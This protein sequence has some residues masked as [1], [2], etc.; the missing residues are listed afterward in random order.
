MALFKWAIA[1]VLIRQAVMVAVAARIRGRVEVRGA[2][3]GFREVEL[4]GVSLLDATGRVAGTAEAVVI[5]LDQQA[6]I[7]PKDM[8]INALIISETADSYQGK[9]GMVENHLLTC[10]DNDPNAPLKNT[11]DYVCTQ[12]RPNGPRAS[13]SGES[14]TW[15]FMISS[16]PSVVGYASKAKS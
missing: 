12:K 3:L 10:L 4:K 9:K 6:K 11:F 16:L 13:S 2:S 5:R 15:L 8:K 14:S 7:E 1:P